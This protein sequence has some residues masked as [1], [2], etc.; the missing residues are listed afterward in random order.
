MP[1][2]KSTGADHT[3]TRTPGGAVIIA[4]APPAPGAR[5][6]HRH[7]GRPAPSHHRAGR[8]RC[9]PPPPRAQPHPRHDREPRRSRPA[10]NAPP[11]P[12]GPDAPADPAARPTSRTSCATAHAAAQYSAAALAT[13]PPR[14][15]V[16]PPVRLTLRRC[17]PHRPLRSSIAC[18]RRLPNPQHERLRGVEMSLTDSLT[19]K[20]KK[21]GWSIAYLIE[22]I[23]AVP[24]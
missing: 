3:S 19:V 16:N 7:P 13:G 9:A 12:P 11:C 10:G 18:G 15:H 14:L 6:P 23:A 22:T 2:R 20:R 8:S 21:A 24:A 1:R 5:P 17:L 4:R